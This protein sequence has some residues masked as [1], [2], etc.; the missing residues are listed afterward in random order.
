MGPLAFLNHIPGI[1]IHVISDSLSPVPSGNVS[2][3]ND[4]FGG[5]YYQP[6]HTMDN[7][8]PLDVLLIPGG[9]GTRRITT[10]RRWDQFIAKIYPNI[11]YIYSVCTGASV[12]ARSGILDGRRAT[13]NKAAF[14]WVMTQGPKV[15]WVKEARWVVDGNIWTSSGEF[16]IWDVFSKPKCVFFEQA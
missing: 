5:E 2:S 9:L 13:T 16:G 15:N 11:Q 3:S 14:A 4:R 7:A 10:D 6:T 12:V 8:P 1:E